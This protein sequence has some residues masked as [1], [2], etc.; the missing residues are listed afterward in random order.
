MRINELL[1]EKEIT[2]S[3]EVFP[4]K[5]QYAYASVQAA[6]DE[7]SG[8]KPDFISVTYR[9]GDGTSQN[10]VGIASHIQ[11]D[12]DVTAIAHLTCVS[13]TREEVRDI[14]KNLTEK[15]IR[16]VLALR[17]DLPREPDDASRRDFQYACQLI[18][19]LKRAGEFCIGAACYPEGHVESANKEA[20]LDRL[21]A[22][23]DCGCSFLVTQMFFDNDVLYRFLYNLS[24]KGISAPVVAGILPV[25]NIRQVKRTLELSGTSLP[26]KFKAILDKYGDKPEAL[27]QAGIAYATEQIIDLAINGVRGVHIYTMNRP[28]TARR[29]TENISDII[30]R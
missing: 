15:G 5:Q 19:E 16:N 6:V 30:A 11:N 28:E 7:L 8:L 24:R 14:A 23:T 4:P 12:L 27:K 29:I 26:P 17:G 20:D 21:K 9:G 22:K 1:S 3:F 2:L 10:T 18:E 25:T 13:S